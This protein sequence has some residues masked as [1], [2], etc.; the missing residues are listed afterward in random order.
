VIYSR[1]CRSQWLRTCSR[2]AVRSAG[3][4]WPYSWCVG[5]RATAIV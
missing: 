5:H 2:F 4:R 1:R 3:V